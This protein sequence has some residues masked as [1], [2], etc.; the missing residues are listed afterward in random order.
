MSGALILAGAVVSRLLG[1]PLS[2]TWIATRATSGACRDEAAALGLSAWPA[3][4]TLPSRLLHCPQGF[5]AAA[6]FVPSV[7]SVASRLVGN[8]LD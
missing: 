6:S 1:L 2:H 8:V 4:L 3:D 7:D 5:L